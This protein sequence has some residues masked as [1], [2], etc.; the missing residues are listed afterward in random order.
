[1]SHLLSCL[2]P[3]S[4]QISLQIPE[5]SMATE[6]TEP[7]LM[8]EPPQSP[9][10]VQLHPGTMRHQFEFYGYSARLLQHSY[11]TTPIAHTLRYCQ[12]VPRAFCR[13]PH[14]DADYFVLRLLCRQSRRKSS[15]SGSASRDRPSPDVVPT[16]VTFAHTDGCTLCQSLFPHHKLPDGRVVHYFHKDNLSSAVRR[17]QAQACFPDPPPPTHPPLPRPPPT[18]PHVPSSL[19]HQ[20]SSTQLPATRFDH[21]GSTIHHALS[22]KNHP[23]STIRNR[24]PPSTFRHG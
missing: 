20:V 21:P 10:V 19:Q 24:H 4:L 13:V 1:M 2:P 6:T 18:I 9:F 16:C 7:G 11:S 3:V 23:A 15:T 8:L 17:R 22:T 5:P 14:Q 12:A